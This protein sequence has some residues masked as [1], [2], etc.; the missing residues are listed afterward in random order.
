MEHIVQ[1]GLTNNVATSNAS[2]RVA[3]PA[4]MGVF[5]VSNSNASQPLWVITG[6]STVTATAG[7][8][9][10]YMIPPLSSRL[11]TPNL[12]TDTHIAGILPSSTGVMGV[13]PINRQST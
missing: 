10:E 9:N 3:L 13:T 8:A 1:A 2:A 12:L 11:V 6:N 5:E 4:G 7:S